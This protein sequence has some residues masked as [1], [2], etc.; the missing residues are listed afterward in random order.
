MNST[1]GSIE[2][3]LIVNGNIT[4]DKLI[5]Y[6]DNTSV[7]YGEVNPLSQYGIT[8]LFLYPHLGMDFGFYNCVILLGALALF[9]H[10]LA[11]VFLKVL[12]KKIN[13]W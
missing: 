10:I 3:Q 2:N 12:V 13:V 6:N 1:I 5:T 7:I 9:F 4:Y 11:Y 8:K